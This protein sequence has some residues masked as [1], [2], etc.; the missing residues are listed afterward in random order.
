MPKARRPHQYVLPN[1]KKYVYHEYSNTLN[2]ESQ[3]ANANVMNPN[4]KNK[5]A[6]K[7]VVI[8]L[9]GSG[10]GEAQRVDGEENEHYRITSGT[11]TSDIEE[12]HYPVTDVG[13]RVGIPVGSRLIFHEGQRILKEVLNRTPLV[14]GYY[15]LQNCVLNC[16]NYYTTSTELNTDY[17]GARKL[18]S[19]DF[20]VR[21][22][23]E[24]TNTGPS[25]TLFSSFFD[26]NIVSLP[27]TFYNNNST[28]TDVKV[29]RSLQILPGRKGYFFCKKC[30]FT[31][32][33][34]YGD[35]DSLCR[36]SRF[37]DYT[38]GCPNN[39]FVYHNMV[40]NSGGDYYEFKHE[41]STLEKVSSGGTRTVISPPVTVA[42]SP[43]HY[44][45]LQNGT[46]KIRSDGGKLGIIVSSYDLSYSADDTDP[47][48]NTSHEEMNFVPPCQLVG[49]TWTSGSGAKFSIEQKGITLEVTEDGATGALCESYRDDFDLAF[50]QSDSRR[51]SNKYYGVKPEKYYYDAAYSIARLDADYDLPYVIRIY[52]DGEAFDLTQ[53]ATNKNIKVTCYQN[54][55]ISITVVGD[56]GEA[57]LVRADK[58]DDMSIRFKY[59]DAADIG[60]R[61]F[62]CHGAKDY[63]FF[64]YHIPTANKKYE[65]TT[66]SSSE[67]F[68]NRELYISGAPNLHKIE[69]RPNGNLVP[70]I[71]A[72]KTENIDFDERRSTIYVN[73]DI[74]VGKNDILKID[75]KPQ[76]TYIETSSD[77]ENK[78]P[79]IG[80]TYYGV[81]SPSSTTGVHHTL[82]SFFLQ[83]TG[84]ENEGDTDAE[85]TVYNIFDIEINSSRVKFDTKIGVAKVFTKHLST[86]TTKTLGMGMSHYPATYMSVQFNA[87]PSSFSETV[88][89]INGISKYAINSNGQPY[90]WKFQY[91]LHPNTCVA[92]TEYPFPAPG[93][94]EGFDRHRSTTNGSG[95]TANALDIGWDGIGEQS[96]S[97]TVPFKF[98]RA[99]YGHNG[100]VRTL[101]DQLH[102]STF[103]TSRIDYHF[104]E[105]LK[106]YNNNDGLGNEQN[107]LNSNELPPYFIEGQYFSLFDEGNNG[108]YLTTAY[109]TIKNQYGLKAEVFDGDGE[110]NV[111]ICTVILESE[112]ERITIKFD[113]APTSS[114]TVDPVGEPE[115]QEALVNILKADTTRLFHLT[116]RTVVDAKI[117]DTLA[118][119]VDANARG[120]PIDNSFSD[121]YTLML[122][123]LGFQPHV[124]SIKAENAPE[125]SRLVRL[126]GVGDIKADVLNITQER[127]LH[128]RQVFAKV[129]S[130]PNSV[131]IGNPAH[132][133]VRDASSYVV[134]RHGIRYYRLSDS[135]THYYAYDGTSTD[136]SKYGTLTVTDMYGRPAHENATIGK[137]R[138][139][140]RRHIEGE[141]ITAGDGRK[142]LYS[143]DRGTVLM[144]SR[145][146]NQ[147]TSLSLN[148]AQGM[149]PIVGESAHRACRGKI[150]LDSYKNTVCHEWNESFGL[151][152]IDGVVPANFSLSRNVLY[153]F[154]FSSKYIHAP[155]T[156]VRQR[157]NNTRYPRH[158]I[159]QGATF[160]V[161]MD[162]PSPISVDNAGQNYSHAP[163]VE[164]FDNGGA[165]YGNESLLVRGTTTISE[166][167]VTSVTLQEPLS[168]YIS[169]VAV[170]FSKE[171]N[172][173][174]VDDKLAESGVKERTLYV[175]RG[176]YYKFK[177][178]E[179]VT[180]H[181]QY[182]SVWVSTDSSTIRDYGMIHQGSH[183]N[184]SQAEASYGYWQCPLN[185]PTK[186]Y[187]SAGDLGLSPI[188]AGGEIYVIEEDISVDLEDKGV[189]QSG[190]IVNSD[191]SGFKYVFFTD[192]ALIKN[193]YLAQFTHEQLFADDPGAGVLTANTLVPVKIDL[194]D[195][196]D[197]A[198]SAG[199]VAIGEQS[200]TIDRLTTF[201]ESEEIFFY[202]DIDFATLFSQGDTVTISG[203]QGSIAGISASEINGEQIVSSIISPNDERTIK[204]FSIQINSAATETIT[205]DVQR[206]TVTY[207][208]SSTLTRTLVSYDIAEVADHRPSTQ[209]QIVELGSTMADAN[210]V[211][212]GN[213][214]K[215][216]T[217]STYNAYSVTVY[218]ENID[219][220]GKIFSIG[221]TVT[222]SG[223]QGVLGGIPADNINGD[224]VITGFSTSETTGFSITADQV[225]DTQSQEASGS[226]N[227]TVAYGSNNEVPHSDV[228][229]IV[230]VAAV[231]DQSIIQITNW[232]TFS[233]VK[234]VRFYVDVDV[235][236]LFSQ[237]DIVTISGFQGSIGG[238]PASE[239]NGDRPVFGIISP[240]DETSINAFSI[241]IT[242]PPSSSASGTIETA[243]VTYDSSERIH[244]HL[245]V[246]M[247]DSHTQ[248]PFDLHEILDPVH[249]FTKLAAHQCPASDYAMYSAVDPTTYSST[250]P[251]TV[252]YETSS[253]PSF[254]INAPFDKIFSDRKITFTLP[255]ES[256]PRTLAVKSIRYCNT[257]TH[258]EAG[259]LPANVNGSQVAATVQNRTMSVTLDTTH[260]GFTFSGADAIGQTPDR[261]NPT[262]TLLLGDTLDLTFE[263]SQNLSFEG[264]GFSDDDDS[265]NISR[266]SS[267]FSIISNS[268]PY[269]IRFTPTTIGN[270]AY[271]LVPTEL[272]AGSYN[273]IIRVARAPPT[274][275]LL[276]VDPFI[277]S[278]QVRD[279]IMEK[280]EQYSSIMASINMT[281][282]IS[283]SSSGAPYMITPSLTFPKH[284]DD[285][286]YYKYIWMI[287]P[288]ANIP[289]SAEFFLRDA[290]RD[291]FTPGNEYLPNANFVGIGQHKNCSE[292][293]VFSNNNNPELLG[294]FSII[295]RRDA[296]RE[297]SDD[298]RQLTEAQL[299]VSNCPRSQPIRVTGLHT[300]NRYYVNR[301][302]FLHEG[303]MIKCIDSGGC[304]SLIVDRFYVVVNPTKNT[305]QLKNIDGDSELPL[306]PTSNTYPK[307]QLA[308]SNQNFLKQLNIRFNQLASS[309]YKLT[310]APSG[311]AHCIY[312][313]NPSRI[314][315]YLALA[316]TTAA[317]YAAKS[318]PNVALMSTRFDMT[319]NSNNTKVEIGSRSDTV[320]TCIRG[321]RYVF[322]YTFLNVDYVPNISKTISQYSPYREIVK[323]EVDRTAAF[324]V[325]FD[326]PDT[327]YYY[328]TNVNDN[329]TIA[330]GEIVVIDPVK[331][332]YELDAYKAYP[333]VAPTRTR[334]K[335]GNI[336]V[337]TGEFK[338]IRPNP[339]I[340]ELSHDKYYRITVMHPDSFEIIHE[341]RNHIL[342]TNI[343]PETSNTIAINLTNSTGVLFRL[344]HED[345]NSTWPDL[346]GSRNVTIDE[347]LQDR[348]KVTG[349]IPSPFSASQQTNKSVR[350]F[351]IKFTGDTPSISYAFVN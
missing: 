68:F 64:D 242:T 238:I 62:K 191:G 240:D 188:Y 320:L 333:E 16:I 273:G 263:A 305:W 26:K 78:H 268:E 241:E 243:T 261:A 237:G 105:S 213:N 284:N 94:G 168:N 244:N 169:P 330:G 182:I 259:Y 112:A 84:V 52:L 119:V 255:L 158:T 324:V 210:T 110:S 116:W 313:K 300:E 178:E 315:T 173:S 319:L 341:E 195:N 157:F 301:N 43:Q 235:A 59:L 80:G 117:S 102:P 55:D 337:H 225:Q 49:G 306:K 20:T 192:D 128:N 17:N 53:P 30:G 291:V 63:E 81:E 189:F 36:A 262:L 89:N 15:F 280:K 19:Y 323:Y 318:Y 103:P 35:Y 27:T 147:K 57:I 304:I 203:L 293:S 164:V 345:P 249:G 143:T 181:D 270:Y 54:L 204:A 314:M 340:S 56:F 176:A 142:R 215:I 281:E 25:P 224:R 279:N 104:T 342:H 120:F 248:R 269:K 205:S 82:G 69:T 317:Q 144:D 108:S 21:L 339:V 87:A 331:E 85:A 297:S 77:I 299:G 264:F 95:I 326:S 155:P 123:G 156:V 150:R 254:D 34:E 290:Y 146:T 39:Y 23:E 79:F 74:E 327:L 152:I 201:N 67:S 265:Q 222:I 139:E 309:T 38:K 171:F 278:K 61:P 122:G 335:N 276:E 48:S 307:F 302:H 73:P 162:A 9:D 37:Y 133:I 165:G 231:A 161:N 177:F 72:G 197:V 22:I 115:G 234:E 295:V 75:D 344:E 109:F 328:V 349:A 187:Y 99:L 134:G 256:A 285:S 118:N 298:E 98:A 347:I 83:Y 246:A 202:G 29:N 277:T 274:H 186:L 258:P 288:I 90:W 154:D 11:F 336:V 33:E 91:S 183:G 46:Y 2:T 260:S 41:S 283:D 167:K 50:G 257:I 66:R 44:L 58:P 223:I 148:G 125:N 140:G 236:S 86:T 127:G 292:F 220:F 145:A 88:F 350:M 42:G 247:Y 28:S 218:N 92:L 245:L 47:F 196:E 219:D 332:Q 217:Y 239:I 275:F 160:V 348:I 311:T 250:L 170:I 149:A 232:F 107:T 126:G 338:I 129:E 272:L 166:G 106:V 65:V 206:V 287:H 10:R 32:S 100:S 212:N 207:S 172:F 351:Y 198:R 71:T 233:N 174:V 266:S 185:G 18:D 209:V 199:P 132:E 163:I 70:E 180:T 7:Y 5:N 60:S 31:F 308:A 113:A 151:T 253:N 3:H 40:Q 312:A 130:T 51:R 4:D 346:S 114:I 6:H 76:R 267:V 96:D 289:I 45:G 343:P 121:D 193:F 159:Y 175:Q 137:S 135:G 211:I 194:S 294:G 14:L 136:D 124:L 227:A 216:L 316:E 329:S 325:P 251:D 179:V 138:A 153:R 310:L 226:L 334:N 221:D 228:N 24:E 200:V 93:S 322:D 208:R 303:D 271:G 97:Y 131:S 214:I 101:F 1:G 12:P 141:C 184:F 321:Q 190:P 230:N 286:I 229:P 282:E 252:R 13:T 8:K 296:L 111:K